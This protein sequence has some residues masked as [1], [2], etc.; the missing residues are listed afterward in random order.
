MLISLLLLSSLLFGGLS[1]KG[2]KIRSMNK[3]VHN[4][5]L[6]EIEWHT[7]VLARNYVDGFDDILLGIRQTTTLKNNRKNLLGA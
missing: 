5:P 4:L 7:C 3:V 6:R 1:S 2:R